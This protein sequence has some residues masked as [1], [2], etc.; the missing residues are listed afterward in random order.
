MLL[1]LL[2]PHLPLLPTLLLL[3]L[4]LKSPQHV[5]AGAVAQHVDV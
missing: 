4:L 5:S 1:P 3:L 2:L